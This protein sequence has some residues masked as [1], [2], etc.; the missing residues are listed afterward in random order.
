MIESRSLYHPPIITTLEFYKMCEIAEV[1]KQHRDSA[2]DYLCKMGVIILIDNN[3]II[4]NPGWVKDILYSLTSFSHSFGKKDGILKREDFSHIFKPPQF[5]AE[6]QDCF[7]DL[8]ES[9]DIILPMSSS[10]MVPNSP[11]LSYILPFYLPESINIHESFNNWKINENEKEYHRIFELKWAPS[12]FFDRCLLRLMKISPATLFWKNLI[13]WKNEKYNGI[14]HFNKRVSEIHVVVASSS[15]SGRL[16]HCISKAIFSLAYGL[17]GETPIHVSVEI[18]NNFSH[19]N[20]SSS[21]LSAP[22]QFPPPPQSLQ[23]PATEKQ[24]PPPP[25]HIL[26]LSNQTSKSEPQQPLQSQSSL[27]Q[28][29]PP[30]LHILRD[31]V[32]QENEATAAPV[33]SPSAFPPPPLHILEL[34][35]QSSKSEPQSAS[36]ANVNN[37]QQ[38]TS[39]ASTGAGAGKES[40]GTSLNKSNQRISIIDIEKLILKGETQ[41]NEYMFDDLVPDVTL[42]CFRR[43]EST[44]DCKIISTLG[45]GG[46]ASVYKAIWNDILV[47]KKLFKIEMAI[48]GRNQLDFFRELRQEVWSLIEHPNIIKLEAVCLKECCLLFEY[49]EYGDLYSYLHKQTETLPF[50]LIL[51]IARDTCKA[52]AYMHSLSP[53]IQHRDIKTPNILLKST[54]PNDSIVAKLTDFGLSSQVSALEAATTAENPDWL[55]PEVL[56]GKPYTNASEVYSFGIVLWELIS[57]QHPFD[58]FSFSFNFQKAE[59]I[60]HDL[61]RP[62]IPAGTPEN[63]AKL[64]TSCWD[65]DPEARPTFDYVQSKIDEMIT[66]C[67]PNP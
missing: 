22:T 23:A 45:E 60:C 46:S 36:Q 50:Q 67:C 34:S 43:I 9:L 13:V 40:H 24:F 2:I 14:V 44:E 30:P 56:L 15:H 39:C 37:Q 11:S 32:K 66:L 6:L 28:F 65:P 41:I 18:P 4:I 49:I 31:N 16:L 10:S 33:A 38:A 53:P 3:T 26:E 25:L 12:G 17:F 54:N 64:I 35:N 20:Q 5:P 57:N 21:S 61:I 62:T 48:L 19:F 1:T 42:K 27:T 63:Y 52:L 59:A 51:A 58:E 55:A 7:I 29:P 47:A 8:L